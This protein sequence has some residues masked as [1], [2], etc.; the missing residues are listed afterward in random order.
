M[1]IRKKGRTLWIIRLISKNNKSGRCRSA[2]V[3]VHRLLA[4]NTQI[5]RTNSIRRKI[6]WSLEY[7]DDKIPWEFT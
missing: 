6:N 2:A 1:W 4:E 7:S 3:N 5:F